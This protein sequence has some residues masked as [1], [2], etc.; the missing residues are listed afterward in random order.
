MYMSAR[1]VYNYSVLPENIYH[2]SDLITDFRGDG[3]GN[4]EINQEIG[5]TSSFPSL[6]H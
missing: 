4:S 5:T 6:H 2:L 1:S 3:N